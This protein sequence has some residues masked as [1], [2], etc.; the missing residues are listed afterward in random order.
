MTRPRIRIRA[1]LQKES[2]L[3]HVIERPHGRGSAGIVA[4][5]R[6]PSCIEHLPQ[7]VGIA[8]YRCIHQRCRP[9]PTASI[10]HT[11]IVGERCPYGRKLARSNRFGQTK[12]TGIR[13]GVETSFA[14]TSGHS[15]PWSIHVFNVSISCWLSGPVGGI[16]VPNSG[17][18]MR[19]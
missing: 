1:S 13:C 15:A 6:V 4:D 11:R 18:M 8:V 17:P 2:C 14:S 16:C 19:R 10:N 7:K 9:G 3:V 5:V 12:C